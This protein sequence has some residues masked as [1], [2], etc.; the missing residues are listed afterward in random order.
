MFIDNFRAMQETN[1]SSHM[2]ISIAGC[3]G[4]RN[5]GVDA[6]V[7]CTIDGLR[8]QFP[9]CKLSLLTW[10]PEYDSQSPSTKDI[11]VI[12]YPYYPR[13]LQVDV[14]SDSTR[15]RLSYR[16]YRMLSN[17]LVG[18][19]VSDST[20]ER[21][22]ICNHLK[23]LIQDCD[24]L[25]ITGGD[26]YSTE[27]GMEGLGYYL[28]LIRTAS[29]C[30]V[31]VALLGHSI[32]R[33]SEQVAQDAWVQA[34]KAISFLS[35]RDQVSYD[36]L[37][38]IQGLPT[39]TFVTSDVAFILDKASK[40][41]EVSQKEVPM[42]ALSISAGIAKWAGITIDDYHRAWSTIINHI[43]DA[44]KCN[45]LLIPHVHETYG[46]DRISQTK[47]LRGL[48][49][50]SRVRVVAED[51]TASEYKAIISTADFLIAERMH[52]AIAG[53]SSKVPTVVVSYSL[54]AHG[55]VHHAY[56]QNTL[57]ESPP[58]Y[59][60]SDYKNYA[61]VLDIINAAWLARYK[62]KTDLEASAPLLVARAMNNF[63]ELA[64]WYHEYS[65]AKSTLSCA[66][67]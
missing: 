41:P 54:K 49:F 37:R 32:G 47:L 45:V 38:S 50:D 62:L 30:N 16:L 43:L 6:L 14:D 63:V 17:A 31:P 20:T 67:M 13:K 51:L 25:V 8:K 18:N 24:L 64:S 36:Y 7:T 28:S 22:Q 15:K 58:I 53:I 60:A 10:T 29:H 39:N 40:F 9:G 19:R 46:D 59:K 34:A 48:G 57:N 42:V 27:Y 3:T 4:F 33:F 52:A 26:I 21:S 11:N 5:R 61:K 35:T 1:E 23:D 65:S 55:L 12:N 2:R 56:S 66:A 44:W